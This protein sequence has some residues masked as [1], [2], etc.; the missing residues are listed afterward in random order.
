MFGVTKGQRIVLSAP[1]YTWPLLN[2]DETVDADLQVLKSRQDTACKSH[3]FRSN[4]PH[5]PG[6][7]EAALENTNKLNRACE[8]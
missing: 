8:T 7:H 5:I 4:I 2:D 1:S 3:P 6:D